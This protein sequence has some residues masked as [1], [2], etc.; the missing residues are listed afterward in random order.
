VSGL[1]GEL[2]GELITASDIAKAKW[3]TL[4]PFLVID[5]IWTANGFPGRMW[6]SCHPFAFERCTES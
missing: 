5:N 2:E 6:Q 1:E 3:R 4:T